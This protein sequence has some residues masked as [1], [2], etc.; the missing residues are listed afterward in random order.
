VAEKTL[1]ILPSIYFT[2]VSPS[3]KFAGIRKVTDTFGYDFGLFA[4]KGVPNDIVERVAKAIHDH[5]GEIKSTAAMWLS[6][7]VKNMGKDQ[8]LPYHPGAEAYYKKIG[9]WKR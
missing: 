5:A 9:I 2:K 7:D 3:P 1:S 6:F 4:H 8:K